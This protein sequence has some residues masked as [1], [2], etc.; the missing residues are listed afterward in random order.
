M[1]SLDTQRA[2]S[3]AAVEELVEYVSR[4]YRDTLGAKFRM[5][6]VESG[7]KV[8]DWLARQHPALDK[9]LEP[10]FFPGT[11]NPI[12]SPSACWWLHQ[13]GRN[14]YCNLWGVARRDLTLHSLFNG[15]AHAIN[16]LVEEDLDNVSDEGWA[17]LAE[18][19]RKL[20]STRCGRVLA[21]LSHSSCPGFPIGVP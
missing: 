11:D 4:L 19:L 2:E 21:R 13:D 1:L 16:C 6:D 7:P 17:A 18:T 12:L 20:S 10:K 9:D 5:L 3:C 8:V 14:M 15:S